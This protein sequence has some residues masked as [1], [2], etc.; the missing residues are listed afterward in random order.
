MTSWPFDISWHSFWPCDHF[1]WLTCLHCMKCTCTY[2]LACLLTLHKSNKYDF[3]QEHLRIF[4][5]SLCFFT[6][7]KDGTYY[8]ITC[9]GWAEGLS[10]T[11][12]CNRKEERIRFARACNHVDDFNE[13][14]L[15]ITNK[16]LQH[17]AIINYVNILPRFITKI[18]IY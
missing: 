12:L 10:G 13:R 11:W 5:L 16:L 6:P 3:R 14:N 17:T 15:F 9:G 1:T 7:I 18:I 2:L 8:V 4:E